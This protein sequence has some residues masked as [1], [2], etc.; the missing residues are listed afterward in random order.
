MYPRSDNEWA[1]VEPLYDYKVDSLVKE[2][3]EPDRHIITI[4]LDSNFKNVI[5]LDINE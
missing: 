5:Y 4:D 2:T 1:G 3:K